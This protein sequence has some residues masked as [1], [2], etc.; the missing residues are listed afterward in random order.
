M[1]GS[2]TPHR[3]LFRKKACT[4]STA[5][6]ASAILIHHDLEKL[7]IFYYQRRGMMAFYFFLHQFCQQRII[8][9]FYPTP[10]RMSTTGFFM[11][12]SANQASFTLVAFAVV[13]ELHVLM[14]A[15]G[16]MRCS[17]ALKCLWGA[18]DLS[19][20]CLLPMRRKLAAILL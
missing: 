12:S 4:A 18:P 14:V 10:P 19:Y 7:R 13:D 15:T 6:E 11:R 20:G 8:V 3:L 1:P 16:S 5:E 9:T 2:A 17:E